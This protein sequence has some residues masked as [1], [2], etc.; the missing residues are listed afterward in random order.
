M[1]ATSIVYICATLVI[2]VLILF[3]GVSDQN[4]AVERYT[5]S[6]SG[7]TVVSINTLNL[8]R[9]S[10]EWNANVIPH[11][12]HQFAPANR[13][14]WHA[15]WSSCH[16][17]WKHHFNAFE[18][19]LW[20]DE[21][22]DDFIHRRFGAVFYDAYSSFAHPIQRLHVA[23]YLVMY[24]YGGIY[25]DMDVECMGDFYE[26]L[27]AGKANLPMN[28]D[29][30]TSHNALMASPAKHPFWHYVLSEIL[31]WRM[32]QDIDSSTGT[33]MLG[34]VAQLVP[35]QMLHPLSS[36]MFIMHGG[37]RQESDDGEFTPSQP[38][39]NVFAIHHESGT[40]RRE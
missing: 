26:Y 14:A 24:E 3:K 22:I 29:D 31:G 37:G 5:S 27:H 9:P 17:S 34:R 25:A 40:W 18:H 10:M 33:K 35:P 28:K 21:A 4:N 1:R 19:H 7:W 32:S 30:D 39:P 2:L 20:T 11:V 36:S 6:S 38:H 12:I 16:E 8:N 23:R 15:S 13:D